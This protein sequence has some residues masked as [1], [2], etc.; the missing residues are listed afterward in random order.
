MITRPPRFTPLVG[1]VALG[2]TAAAFGGGISPAIAQDSVPIRFQPG[3]TS[4]TINGTIIGNAYIDYVLGARAGQTMVV[5]LAVT[6]TNGNGSAFFNIVPAG[7]DFP[8][9]FNGSREGRRA[10][11]TLPESG[12][13]AIRVYL[14]G[15]DADTGKTV[16]YSIDVYIAPGGGA[17]GAG[18]PGSGSGLL[19]EED[20]FVVRTSGGPL[21]V[22]DAPRPGAQKIG[23]HRS[24]TVLRNAGG[25]TMSDGQQWCKV[26]ASSGGV[27]GWVA[28]RFLGL[29]G[30]GDQGAA[31]QGGGNMVRV[32]GVPA[33][34]VLNVRSGPGTGNRIVGALANGD[35]VRMLG[36]QNVGSAR[37]CEIEM[38]S[39]MRE[40]GW[41][42][43]RYL[44]GE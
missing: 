42:N 26:Q 33:N 28:A 25:C 37:W 22:R 27:I 30:P 1:A 24:G 7:Q 17:L 34:D 32:T 12:D 31:A 23:E 13:W 21:N 4:T 5:S 3:A 35:N 20:F 10:E 44:T 6:G 8:A 38:Q 16:G 19:P 18:F 2:L 14:M 15:N 9:L 39:D 40:R 11:V 41:V 43:A 29:P 36:C